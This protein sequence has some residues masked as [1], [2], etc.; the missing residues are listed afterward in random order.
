MWCE[1]EGWT[2]ILNNQD[3]DDV[4]SLTF[5]EFAKN[6]LAFLPNMAMVPLS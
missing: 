4:S 6:G 1:P 2:V 3:N 5:T